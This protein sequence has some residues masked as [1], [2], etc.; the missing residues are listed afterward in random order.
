LVKH[1]YK[2]LEVMDN[3]ARYEG[4]WNIA[5]K[6]REGMG[7]LIWQDGS[8]YEGYWKDDKA[9]GRGRLIHANK[10]VYIG[11]WKDDKAHGYGFYLHADGAKYE[12]F[13]RNDK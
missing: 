11:E 9:N 1:E 4:E 6:K 5:S 3:K 7:I 10:D 12:G 2:T 13:W 8:V